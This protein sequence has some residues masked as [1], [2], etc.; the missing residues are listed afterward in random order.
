MFGIV[1]RAHWTLGV[2]PEHRFAGSISKA[3]LAEA[4]LV[5]SPDAGADQLEATIAGGF[6]QGIDAF[7]TRILSST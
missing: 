7:V 6:G 1:R 3:D 5:R 4:A 2:H